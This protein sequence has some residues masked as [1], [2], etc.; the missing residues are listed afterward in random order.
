M[1]INSTVAFCVGNFM[2]QELQRVLASH[3]LKEEQAF[4][5]IHSLQETLS[6]VSP[7]EIAVVRTLNIFCDRETC[8]HALRL[9]VFAEAIGAALGLSAREVQWVRLA[10]LLHDIGKAGMASDILAKPGPLGEEEWQKIRL[11]PQ[12]GQHILLVAGGVFA[13][14]A[15]TVVSHHERWD[16]AGYPVG[17]SGEAIPKWARILAVID[18]Y[19][20]MTSYRPYRQPLLLEQAYHELEQGAGYQYDPHVVAAFLAVLDVRRAL[21]PPY[22][23]RVMFIPQNASQLEPVHLDYAS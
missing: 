22:I 4:L 16:G 10:A 12:I 2:R 20:A 9:S 7:V 21:K 8:A 19:D 6:I 11:H 3:V 15:A 17:L 1:F 5:A 13:S 23:P 14:L 18:S